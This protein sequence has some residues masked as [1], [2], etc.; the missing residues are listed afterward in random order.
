MLL[1]K[2]FSY[3]Y[4][5]YLRVLDEDGEDDALRP[6]EGEELRAEDDALRLEAAPPDTELRVVAWLEE[7][8]RAVPEFLVAPELLVVEDLLPEGDTVLI[9]VFAVPELLTRLRTVVCP[10]GDPAVWED[11]LTVPCPE[12]ELLALV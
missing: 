11:L 3:L 5:V 9:L 6:P 4:V 10:W 2:V 7:V 12:D 1:E 8:L